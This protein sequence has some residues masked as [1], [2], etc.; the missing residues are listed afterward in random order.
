LKATS[1]DGPERARM[2]NASAAKAAQAGAVAAL[3]ATLAWLRTRRTRGRSVSLALVTLVLADLFVVGRSINTL[4]P[5][6]LL[7]AR[8][9]L[10]SHTRPGARVWVSTKGAVDAA[11]GQPRGS[12]GWGHEWSWAWATNELLRPPTGARWGMRGSYDGD[13]TGLAPPLLSNLTLIMHHADRSPLGVRLLQMG[14]VDYVLSL[15]EWPL[16]SPVAERPSVFARPIR[17]YRV[18]GALA[19]AYVVGGSRVAAEPESVETIADPT[20]DPT[21]EVIVPPGASALRR[22]DAFRGSLR[23]LW[24]R[25]DSLGLEVE[26]TGPAYTVVLEAFETGWKARVD[27]RSAPIVPANV[28]FQAVAVPGGKHLVSLEYRPASVVWGMAL[29]GIGL[30]LGLVVV[31]VAPRRPADHLVR[32]SQQR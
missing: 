10:L 1:A 27:G 25:A 20:F 5:P 21:R 6:E 28:L 31:R 32:G 13:F 23:E 16:L 17:L 2:L 24:R 18:P 30:S 9:A 12:A 4:A 22:D 11:R 3:V 8:P 7:N 19:S 15:D 29:A 26:T 14:G